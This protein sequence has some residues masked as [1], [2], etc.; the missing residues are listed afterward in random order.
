MKKPLHVLRIGPLVLALAPECETLFSLKARMIRDSEIQG[1]ELLEVYWQGKEPW[2]FD[3]KLT[4]KEAS[5]FL[6]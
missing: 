6:A 1:A 5:R 4:P 3:C 2:I